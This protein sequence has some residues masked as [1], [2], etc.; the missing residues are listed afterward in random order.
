MFHRR[1]PAAAKYRSLKLLIE[2]RTTHIAV[3]VDRSRRVLT[4]VGQIRRC[5]ASQTLKDQDGDPEGHSLTHGQPVKGPVH[6]PLRGCHSTAC[7][8]HAY[9][10]AVRQA[11]NTGAITNDASETKQELSCC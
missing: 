11:Y 1:G 2:R 10:H 5:L 6:L 4:V 8:K 3:S 7:T 9:T